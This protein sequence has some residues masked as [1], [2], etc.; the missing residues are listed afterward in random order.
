MPRW[1]RRWIAPTHWL[2]HDERVELVEHRQSWRRRLPSGEHELITAVAATP[3]DELGGTAAHVL[4][5]RL[6]IRRGEARERIEEAADL[7][8]R[9]TL[10]RQPLPPKLQAT[11]AGQ[12]AGLI[13]H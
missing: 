1:M 6:R 3:R 4:A 10:T 8:A 2:S 12:R 5:G 9:T 11:A 7:G 13:D